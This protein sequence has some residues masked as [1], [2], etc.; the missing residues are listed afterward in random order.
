MEN[1]FQN[2]NNNSKVSK[3]EILRFLFN[4]YTV[5]SIFAIL[6]LV[7]FDQ[8]DVRSQLKLRTKINYLEEQ[9]KGFEKA[10]NQLRNER[11]L[12]SNDP[13]ELERIARETYL[14]KRPNEDVYVVVQDSN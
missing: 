6:W 2:E 11:H 5:V 4:R 3:K 9:K 12:L 7:V 10:I 8:F 13:A 14:M 1:S